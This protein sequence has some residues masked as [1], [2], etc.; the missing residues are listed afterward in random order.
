MIWDI[1]T[2]AWLLNSD[3]VPSN[4][5]HSPLLADQVTWSVDQSRHLVRVANF[6]HRDPIFRDMFKK[7][8]ALVMQTE[9]LFELSERIGES[10]RSTPSVRH[11]RVSEQV[12]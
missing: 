11:F 9:D 5:V 1:S 7:M 12:V 6:V 4:L 3:W 10:A 2:I 8:R